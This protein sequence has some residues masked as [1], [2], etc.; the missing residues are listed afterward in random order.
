M[1]ERI[2][3]QIEQKDIKQIKKQLHYAP[4]WVAKIMHFLIHEN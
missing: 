3:S 2:K 1:V 4:A